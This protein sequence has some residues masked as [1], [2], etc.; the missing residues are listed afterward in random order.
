[1]ASTTK[2]RQTAEER[3][4]AIAD[5]AFEE[6]ALRGL[7][8]TPTSEIARKAGISHAYLFRLFPTKTELFITATER[9]F[10]RTLEAFQKAAEGKAPG[11]E[12]LEAMG[13]AY[14]ELLADRRL[15]LSQMHAYAACDDPGI[16]AAV[17]RRYG[18]LVQFV[19]RTSG[20]DPERVRE[21]FAMGM[22]LN[23]AAA[24]NLPE[25]HEPWVERLLPPKLARDK[26]G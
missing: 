24:M 11:D 23:V 5:I 3:R 17:Q 12:T 18:E 2:T 26:P 20:A 22:L 19:E 21:F 25:L 1:M 8:G 10:D 16:R 14:V 9:C 6:F 7:H 13:Q 4:E 15:L